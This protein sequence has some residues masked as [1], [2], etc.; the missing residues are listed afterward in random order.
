MECFKKV[1]NLTLDYF[2]MQ[3]QR[4]EAKEELIK[5]RTITKSS[6]LMQIATCGVHSSPSIY[7]SLRSQHA[8]ER[9]L[10]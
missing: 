2:Y 5:R 6:G 4:Q 3:N 10:L 1:S 8:I 7:Y 9:I